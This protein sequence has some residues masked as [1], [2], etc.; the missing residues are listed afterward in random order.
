MKTCCYVWVLDLGTC[1]CVGD[2]RTITL[3][4]S[5]AR[6]PSVRVSGSAHGCFWLTVANNV[7]VDVFVGLEHISVFT[8]DRCLEVT[9]L[10]WRHPGAKVCWRPWLVCNLALLFTGPTSCVSGR[11]AA[12]FLKPG[13]VLEVGC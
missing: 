2:R 13:S 4:V 11:Y 5:I 6:Y 8:L 1:I 3:A 10:S 12:M 9:F 7:A